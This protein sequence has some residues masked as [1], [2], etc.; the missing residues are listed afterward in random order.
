MKTDILFALYKDKVVCP[1]K[2]FEKIVG[3]YDVNISDLYAKITSYQ[4]DTY[5]SILNEY[6]GKITK[7]QNRI[8]ADLAR[9]RKYKKISRIKQQEVSNS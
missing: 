9:Q 1:K 8:A 5:G 7:H 4:V 6:G 2:K 3:K